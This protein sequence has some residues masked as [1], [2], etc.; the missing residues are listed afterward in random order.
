M[1]EIDV[2]GLLDFPYELQLD[3][4][5]RGR[6]PDIMRFC[7]TSKAAS[8]ICDD[9][10]FWKLKTQRD[11][12]NRHKEAMGKEPT[13]T[14]SW[15]EEYE[16]YLGTLGKDL[17]E[18]EKNN[19]VDE[20]KELVEFG[21]DINTIDHLGLTPLLSAARYN[22]IDMAALLIRLG[23]DVQATSIYG[24]TALMFISDPEIARMLIKGGVD[25]NA[26]DEDG[27]TT[28][29]YASR[30]NHTQVAQLLIDS[31]ADVNARG[32]FSALSE[33]AAGNRPEI[34]RM[35]LDAD[36]DVNARDIDGNTALYAA[37]ISKNPRIIEMVT[38]VKKKPSRK[39]PPRRKTRGEKREEMPVKKLRQLAK[40]NGLKGYSRLRRAEL[41]TFLDKH[42]K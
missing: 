31:K 41:L 5:I 40:D 24:H 33:S 7:V 17:L 36:A 39:A 28:L 25:V 35:L 30:S 12:S 26:T 2:I 14:R 19:D 9:P 4:L 8:K 42:L 32:H 22:R 37:H 3:T 38:N 11:F 15:R 20:V 13:H 27:D 21:V 1:E 29:M 23:A 10:Y 16:Y 34:V 6:Y 18:A